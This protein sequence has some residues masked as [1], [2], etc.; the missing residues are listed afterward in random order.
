MT[1]LLR[2]G[3]HVIEVPLDGRLSRLFLFTGRSGAVLFDTGCAGDIPRYVLPYLDSIGLD[4]AGVSHVVVSHCDVDHFGGLGDAAAAFPQARRLAHALDAPVME[5]EAYLAG[6]AREFALSDALDES[7]VVID[8][9]RAAASGGTLTDHV[10]DGSL[11]DLGERAL[12]VLHVPGHSRGHLAL[13]DPAT[14]VLAVSDAV[15]GDYVPLADGSPS[16]PPTYR[17]AREYLATVR[18]LQGI[19]FE[20]LATAHYPREGPDSGR[21]LLA[22]SADFAARLEE[23]LLSVLD[24]ATEP[25]SLRELVDTLGPAV[26]SWPQEGRGPALAQPVM[27]HLEDLLERGA[28]RHVAGS[29]PAWVRVAGS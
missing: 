5:V 20:V 4:H 1:G 28:V 9:T 19:D 17:H 25:V 12:E 7:Q 15:L 13:W 14:G 6:R 16:F 10:G 3:V 29:P 8:W 24:A 22:K 27:G 11:L 21:D 23:R 26:G 2:P 18:R